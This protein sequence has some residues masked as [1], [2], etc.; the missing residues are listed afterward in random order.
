MVS[1]L[2][3][4]R[5]ASDSALAQRLAQLTPQQFRV[6]RPVSEGGIGAFEPAARYD[7]YDFTDAARGGEGEAWTFGVNWYLDDWSRLMFD[8]AHWKTD[9]KVGS[10]QGPDSRNTLGARMQVAF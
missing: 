8:L 4:E 9:H 3:A 10:Y 6:L 7:K 1:A 2:T 5:S